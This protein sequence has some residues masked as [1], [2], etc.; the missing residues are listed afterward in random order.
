[1]EKSVA[2]G[3]TATTNSIVQ[4]LEPIESVRLRSAAKPYLEL[5]VERF[6]DAL[7][8]DDTSSTYLEALTAHLDGRVEA[9]IIGYRRTLAE[10]AHSA[11]AMFSLGVLQVLRGDI[12]DGIAYIGRALAL[13]PPQDTTN[14]VIA[15]FHDELGR[16]ALSVNYYLRSLVLNPDDFPMEA[17]L[18]EV[19][20]MLGRYDESRYHAEKA[21]LLAPGSADG[22]RVKG[23]LLSDIGRVAEARECYEAAI[24]ADPASTVAYLMLADIGDIDGDSPH[25]DTLRRMLEKGCVSTHDEANVHFALGRAAEAS[26]DYRDAVAHYLT[27]CK[28]ERSTI[29]YG[30]RDE[31]VFGRAQASFA[32]YPPKKQVLGSASELPV[33]VVGMPR[34]GSTLIEQILSSHPEVFGAG[35]VPTFERAV[36]RVVGG[37]A[38]DRVRTISAEQF[39]EIGADYLAE[40]RGSCR[41]AKRIVNKMLSNYLFLGMIS[42][43]LPRARVIH[44][45]RDPVD[46]CVSCLSH[47][48]PVPYT[49]DQ[50]EVGRTYRLYWDLMQYWETVLPRGFILHVSYEDVVNDIETQARRI[51]QFCG[52]EWSASC[53]AF[54]ENRRPVNTASSVQVRR[55]L[56]NNSVGRW[57][58]CADMLTPLFDALGEDFVSRA[59]TRAMGPKPVTRSL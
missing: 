18:A 15:R 35:E 46:T 7:P 19:L 41:T 16:T 38:L 48:F 17:R 5:L 26:K 42:L 49:F 47:L 58:A 59:A 54:Y 57:A 45:Y 1:M 2:A 14:P 31:E 6:S 51:I 24:R 56:Y 4:N 11:S 20:R 28:L 9:A 53:L 55:K 44:I 10:S 32:Q 52:L 8:E 3:P 34:S 36:E 23:R 21:L 22:W 29:R 43:A 39:M 13:V 27:G 30:P 37:L 33:F 12:D 25:C 50:T 40:M